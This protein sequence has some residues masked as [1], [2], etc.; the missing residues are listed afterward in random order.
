MTTPAP[1][2]S[3]RKK[4]ISMLMMGVTVPTAENASLLTKLPTTHV[5]TMLYSCWN[6]LPSIRGRAKLMRCFV[7]LPFVMSTS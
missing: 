2:D 5:S 3:P 7:M 4:P 6:R 1:L